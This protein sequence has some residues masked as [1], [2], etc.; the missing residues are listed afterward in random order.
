MFESNSSCSRDYNQIFSFF[1]IILRLPW[2]PLHTDLYLHWSPVTR[3]TVVATMAQAL[4]PLSFS[5]SS[6][7]ELFLISHKQAYL[8]P[9]LSPEIQSTFRKRFRNGEE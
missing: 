6:Y 7:F 9:R 5:G 1:C 2:P 8:F 3:L 4:F